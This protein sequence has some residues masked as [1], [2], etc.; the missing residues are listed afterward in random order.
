MISLI[1]CSGLPVLSANSFW[2]M[3]R[4]SSS[5]ASNSPGGTGRSEKSRSMVLVTIVLAHLLYRHL[6][7]IVREDYHQT[8]PPPQSNCPLSFLSSFQFMYPK[9]SNRP[10]IL[11]G[12]C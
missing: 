10:D 12:C 7:F 3:P 4:S 11:E 1:L 9:R 5:S 2:L 8:K 6:S